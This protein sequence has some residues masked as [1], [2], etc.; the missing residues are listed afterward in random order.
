MLLLFISR[1]QSLGMR[2]LKR[3]GKFK[4]AKPL[5]RKAIAQ[6]NTSSISIANQLDFSQLP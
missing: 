1:K 3:A 5:Q 6:T 4:D 2:N